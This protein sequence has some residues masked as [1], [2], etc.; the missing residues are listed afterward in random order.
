MFTKILFFDFDDTLNNWCIAQSEV[1]VL[2]SEYFLKKHK[3]PQN[4]FFK[5]FN[6]V[7][8]ELFE[9]RDGT[10][11]YSRRV[12]IERTCKVLD[13]NENAE[14]LED[15]YWHNAHKVIKL[16]D[17]VEETLKYLKNKGYTLALLSDSD[18]HKIY[19]LQRLDHL[20]LMDYFDYIFTGDD[21]DV[22]KPHKKFFVDALS[23]INY[24]QK[25]MNKFVAKQCMM[26]G[27]NPPLDLAIPKKL[28]MRTV[29]T[30]Q[31]VART[32]LIPE[33]VDKKINHIS[34]LKEIL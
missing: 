9:K 33:Y 10:K 31:S 29:W 13:I 16:L 34:E 30:T 26:I 25:S 5:V 1:H 15:V 7:R 3:I 28:G 19:K 32:N 21:F 17:G 20:N 18:G 11:S 12:W 4:E 8:K 23:N 6:D 2:L 27:D 22:V 24:S 14:Q